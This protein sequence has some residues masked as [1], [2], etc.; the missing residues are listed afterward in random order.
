MMSKGL[1]KAYTTNLSEDEIITLKD[2]VEKNPEMA[3]DIIEPTI[4]MFLG[5]IE[6]NSTLFRDTLLPL[7][8][9]SP[10]REE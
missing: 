5:T 10:L 8:I 6:N 3:I 1:E 7:M 9:N 2:L 4:Q